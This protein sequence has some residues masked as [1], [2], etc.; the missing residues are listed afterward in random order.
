MVEQ[1]EPY[2]IKDGYSVAIEKAIVVCKDC[3]AEIY[4]CQYC[5][6]YLFIG[7]KIICALDGFHY[8]ED[9]FAEM[10]SER[11]DDGDDERN[12]N[13]HEDYGVE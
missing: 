4:L 2:V 6:D 13:E 12:P 10:K 11:D 8:H 3:D 7:S 5:E 1:T 9:C